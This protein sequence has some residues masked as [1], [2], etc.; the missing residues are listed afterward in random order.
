GELVGFSRE[1]QAEADELQVLLM[2]RLYRNHRVVRMDSKARRL[3][4]ELFE[5]YLAEPQLLPERFASRLAEQ[6]PHRVIC[7]YIAG[8]TDRFCQEEHRRLFAPFHFD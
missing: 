8:M 4:R 2:E 6:G 5:A 1:M 7:D 3:I